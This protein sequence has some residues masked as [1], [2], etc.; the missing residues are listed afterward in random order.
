MNAFPP[1]LKRELSQAMYLCRPADS[2]K[3]STPRTRTPIVE[4]PRELATEFAEAVTIFSPKP[5]AW[6]ARNGK[7]SLFRTLER[8]IPEVYNRN[9]SSYDKILF[10]AEK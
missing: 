3:R 1:G 4:S 6:V 5:H 8:I 7:E 10:Q 2:L 9:D